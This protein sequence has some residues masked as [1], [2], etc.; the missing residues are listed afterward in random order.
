MTK[1]LITCLGMIA[2]LTAC[3]RPVEVAKPPIEKKLET[4]MPKREAAAAAALKP[5]D[6]GDVE[7][8]I[9]I[10]TN[11]A[12]EAQLQNI[13]A[14]ESKDA[15]PKLNM[16]ELRIHKPYPLEL[17]FDVTARSSVDFTTCPV[18]IRVKILLD[19]I[20][21]GSFNGVVG[22]SPLVRTFAQT[23]IDILKGRVTLP[24]SML[25]TVKADALLMPEGTDIATI[26][27]VTATTTPERRTI[28]LGNPVRIDFVEEEEEATAEA[29]A[30]TPPVDATDDPA[31]AQ[32]SDTAPVDSAQP[33]TDA[34]PPADQ[35]K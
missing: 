21:I 23:K 1:S 11:L 6:R 9:F 33:P 29:A 22:K 34:T 13:E 31:A 12:K 15:R 30:E 28:I 18:V 4:G 17:P 3:N 25:L 27:P 16:L 24:K 26:D 32:P 5:K 20:E 35:P 10:E 19:G 14:R 7:Q 2:F 8:T